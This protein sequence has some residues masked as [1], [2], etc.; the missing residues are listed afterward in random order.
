MKQKV[1]EKIIHKKRNVKNEGNKEELLNNLVKK[2]KENQIENKLFDQFIFNWEKATDEY[3]EITKDT[4]ICNWLKPIKFKMELAI[5][6][7][8]IQKNIDDV[9]DDRE[10]MF[11][12]MQTLLNMEKA[13]FYSNIR[14][15]QNLLIDFDKV[16]KCNNGTVIIMNSHRKKIY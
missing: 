13:Y 10:K 5:I 14:D 12:I 9:L 3:V 1:K 7:E 4:N 8:A 11:N 15:I 16:K 2:L 6:I